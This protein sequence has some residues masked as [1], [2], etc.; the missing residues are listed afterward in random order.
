MEVIATQ[1][2]VDSFHGSSSKRSLFVSGISGLSHRHEQL[3][4]LSLGQPRPGVIY[5]QD[6]AKRG[7]YYTFQIGLYAPT[8]D[9]TSI[10]VAAGDLL[11][12]GNQSISADRITCFN[13]EGIDLNGQPF[14][15]NFNVPQA[16]VQPL[17]IGDRHSGG[18][19]SLGFIEGK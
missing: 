17:W 15:K 19:T 7:E 2:E 13:T 18:C 6:E 4:T 16:Q 3:P 5:L 11:A 14:T 1:A 9:L 12:K 8:Q 10:T